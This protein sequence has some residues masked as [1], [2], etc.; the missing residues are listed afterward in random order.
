V[1][2]FGEDPRNELWDAQNAIHRGILGRILNKNYENVLNNRN[3]LQE[4]KRLYLM[5]CKKIMLRLYH[6]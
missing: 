4:N 2:L 5:F 3:I 1:R 6:P